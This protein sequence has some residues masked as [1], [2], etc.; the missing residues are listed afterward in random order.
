[1]V[2]PDKAVGGSDQ[3]GQAARIERLEPADQAEQV[4]HEPVEDPCVWR[5]VEIEASPEQVWEILATD[6]G[7]EL[8]LEPDPDRNLEVTEAD[9]PNRLVWWWGHDDEPPRRVEFLVVAAPAGT[10]VIVIESEPSL[11][12][13]ML[14]AAPATASLALCLAFA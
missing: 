8:W 12:L 6:A 7:R 2:E 13:A 4:D 10:R 14:A 3:F 1:M 11:P 9:P 5:E